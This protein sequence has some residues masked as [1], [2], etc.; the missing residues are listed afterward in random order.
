MK[1]NNV[2]SGGFLIAGS[3]FG[4]GTILNMKKG[5]FENESKY[6]DSKMEQHSSTDESELE[7]EVYI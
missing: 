6:I 2:F 3:L 5:P 1:S 7:A 4:V